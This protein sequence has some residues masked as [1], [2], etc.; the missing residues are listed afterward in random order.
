MDNISGCNS[1]VCFGFDSKSVCASSL[2]RLR[3]HLLPVLAVS[4][5]A[6]DVRMDD[7]SLDT[8]AGR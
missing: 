4:E 7:L 6:V 8:N 3:P 5:G 2:Q 1:Q